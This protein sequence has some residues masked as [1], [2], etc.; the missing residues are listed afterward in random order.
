MDVI[1]KS[2]WIRPALSLMTLVTA[3][4]CAIVAFTYLRL[5]N[6]L[7]AQR[8][9]HTVA[10]ASVIAFV[11]G[12]ELCLI[13]TSPIQAAIDT[14]FVFWSTNIRGLDKSDREHLLKQIA[15]N[16]VGHGGRDP[17]IEARFSHRVIQSRLEDFYIDYDLR[18]AGSTYV[19]TGWYMADTVLCT[20]D[21][22]EEIWVN[23]IER[24]TKPDQSTQHVYHTIV[25]P[26]AAPPSD[27]YGVGGGPYQ[28]ASHQLSQTDLTQPHATHQTVHHTV[29]AQAPGTQELSLDAPQSQAEIGGQHT[30]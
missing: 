18:G 17:V 24:P 27:T 13:L 6:P 21:H 8:Q 14:L 15:D 12:A 20:A 5:T 4:I 1:G 7:Y 28:Q 11:V 25:V 2:T 26:N 16:F 22:E 9:P 3:C 19:K 29:V 23:G 10:F 30:Y